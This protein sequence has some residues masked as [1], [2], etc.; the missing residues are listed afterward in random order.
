MGR[1]SSPRTGFAGLALAYA[2]LRVAAMLAERKKDLRPSPGVRQWGTQ[3]MSTTD[4]SPKYWL[5]NGAARTSS[6]SKVRCSLSA[7]ISCSSVSTA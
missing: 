7:N 1:G 2:L 5:A 6:G 4:P 3:S